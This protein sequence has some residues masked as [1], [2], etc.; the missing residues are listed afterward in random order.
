MWV[1]VCALPLVAAHWPCAAEI[2]DLFL[3]SA[4]P[5]SGWEQ[6]GRAVSMEPRGQGQSVCAVCI[7]GFRVL[8][9]WLLHMMPLSNPEFPFLLRAGEFLVVN[10]AEAPSKAG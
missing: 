10:F 5:G 1:Q 6:Q 4:S 3:W 7:P 8:L 2:T 9:V